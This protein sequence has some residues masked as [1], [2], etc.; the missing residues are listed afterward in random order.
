[1]LTLGG[2]SVQWV[3]TVR[4][5]G[6]F[7]VRSRSFKCCSYHAKQTIYRAF[8]S[9]Y[10]K[11]DRRASEEVPYLLYGLDACPISTT[12]VNSLN[13]AINRILFKIF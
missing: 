11:I 8:N 13:F 4:Y 5:L 12:D 10:D 6:A 7:I 9:I 1:M 2:D 3:D